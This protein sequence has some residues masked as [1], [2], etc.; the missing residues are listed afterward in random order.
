MNKEIDQVFK[1][2]K[3]FLQLSINF[4]KSMKASNVCE[5]ESFGQDKLTSDRSGDLSISKVIF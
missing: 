1:F 3:E 4:K 5:Y 2:W